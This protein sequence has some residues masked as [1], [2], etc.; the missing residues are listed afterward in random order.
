MNSLFWDGLK[1]TGACLLLFGFSFLIGVKVLSAEP[2]LLHL[3]FQDHE[4]RKVDVSN[5]TLVLVVG[6][7]VDKL[8]LVLTA[9]GLDLK[10]DASWLRSHWPGGSNRIKNMDRAYVFL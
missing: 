4:G 3:D 7:Y 9:E 1:Y 10:L 8:P 6:N 2:T 5:A